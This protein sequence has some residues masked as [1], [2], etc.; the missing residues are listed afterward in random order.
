MVKQTYN[1]SCQGGEAHGFEPKTSAPITT[2][3]TKAT[4]PWDVANNG[5]N[6]LNNVEIWGISE[7]A[8]PITHPPQNPL[9]YYYYLNGAWA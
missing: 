6:N 1:K 2:K 7:G 8:W 9:L 5:A 3:A 4:L